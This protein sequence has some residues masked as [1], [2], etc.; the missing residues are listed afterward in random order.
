MCETTI[1]IE[2]LRKRLT[3]CKTL[4]DYQALMLD[5]AL[6]IP[7][8]TSVQDCRAIYGIVE[9][10][11]ASCIDLSLSPEGRAKCAAGWCDK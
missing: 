2:E 6:S 4:E 8:F 7:F 10:C 5:C 3:E 1:T 9:T 11:A